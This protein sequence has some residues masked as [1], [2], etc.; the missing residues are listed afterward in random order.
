MSEIIAR[1]NALTET[2]MDT[3]ATILVADI[4]STDTR[5]AG[6]WTSADGQGSV[7]MHGATLAEARAE[8]LTQRS[9]DGE[10]ERILAGRLDIL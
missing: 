10:R 9:T 4:A 6:Y 1:T 5:T 7:S 2:T 8:L 3:I